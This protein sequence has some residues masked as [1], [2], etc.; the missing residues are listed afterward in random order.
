MTDALERL[1]VEQEVAGPRT[2]GLVPVAQA[3]ASAGGEQKKFFGKPLTLMSYL[4]S[5]LIWRGGQASKLHP[6][7][8]V[9]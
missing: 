8:T 7:Q 6:K 4:C 1:E 5:I 2:V 9:P 3:I